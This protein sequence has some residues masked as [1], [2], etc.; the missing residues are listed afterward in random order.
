MKMGFPVLS[1]DLEKKNGRLYGSY[2]QCKV[3][4]DPD[5]L[6][7]QLLHLVATAKAKLK[8]PSGDDYK[9][10]CSDI[11]VTFAEVFSYL[12]TRSTEFSSGHLRTLK[13]EKFIPCE[14]KDS[15][16]WY[17][18]TDVYFKT[19]SK[20][21]DS[22]TEALFHVIDFSPFLA[23]AGVQSE[24]RTQDI[25]RLML[26]SPGE[27]LA[28]LGSEAKYRALLRRIAAN[29]PFQRVTP[30]IRN[31]PF[32]LAYKIQEDDEGEGM[33]KANY[34]LAKAE[35]TYIIDNSF[36]GRMFPV[37]RAPHESDLED[38]YYSLGSSYI[39]KQ[40]STSYEVIACHKSDTALT[41]QL[42]QRIK[43]RSPLLSLRMSHRAHWYP[44]PAP[45]LM[46]KICK[47]SKLSI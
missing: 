34:L 9:R 3:H 24:A 8:Q 30:S 31:A 7:S 17:E 37:I 39:S 26:S 25:F 29:P 22:L 15:I 20:E 11:L 2:F 36:L 13:T 16:E 33:A 19:S 38:F 4:P 44:T 18:P 41:T 28:T 1:P 12:S 46:T 45:Y 43:E 5:Q 6:L 21:T 40:V 42:A 14:V 47:S 10:L 23:A 32:L 35:D 27:V